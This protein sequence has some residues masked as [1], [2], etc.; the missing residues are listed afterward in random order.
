MLSRAPIRLLHAASARGAGRGPAN[1]RLT[2]FSLG[3]RKSGETL[4]RAFSAGRDRQRRRRAAPLRRRRAREVSGGQGLQRVSRSANAPDRPSGE[5]GPG[6]ASGAPA[7]L[8]P[9]SSPPRCRRRPARAPISARS[10][11]ERDAAGD[12]H[13]RPRHSAAAVLLGS[14]R[15]AAFA[16][17]AA[18]DAAGERARRRT[19]PHPRRSRSRQ[20][21]PGQR[22]ADSRRL[23]SARQR[24]AHRGRLR[25]GRRRAAA[26][27]RARVLVLARARARRH[28][29]A[30]G[31]AAARP[32]RG[33]LD[34]RRE[35]EGTPF[36]DRRTRGRRLRG[37]AH[38]RRVGRPPATGAAAR[39][40][41]RGPRRA[42]RAARAARRDPATGLD[43]RR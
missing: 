41:R 13:H 40:P 34:R 26:A 8:P 31:R 3:L 22:A 16:G 21:L 10:G 18:L 4:I 28:G 37:H 25:A 30:G 17:T 39:Q 1:D 29:A 7:R 5:A 35:P 15:F 33:V 2:T 36:R 20:S 9:S 32:R 43:A 42:R 24:A 11:V 6:E 12:G 38:S 23:G 27:P 14:D 19:R